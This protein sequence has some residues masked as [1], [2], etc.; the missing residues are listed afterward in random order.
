[1][2]RLQGPST[3]TI[4]PDQGLTVNQ[5]PASSPASS[6]AGPPSNNAA[7]AST[8]GVTGIDYSKWDNIGTTVSD[9]EEDEAQRLRDL[10]DREEL[11]ELEL[12]RKLAHQQK[13][14]QHQQSS[15]SSS[16]S[17]SSRVSN[18]SISTAEQK[19]PAQQLTR[20]GGRGSLLNQNH[21][22]STNFLWSQTATSLVLNF[23]VPAW[24]RAKQVKVVV[25]PDNNGAD[26]AV[27][28]SLQ[29]RHF[30]C[31]SVQ[32]PTPLE[33]KRALAHPIEEVEE[34]ED[35][36]W[37]LFDFCDKRRVQVSLQKKPFAKGVTLWWKKAFSDQN[38]GE[39]IDVTSISD[40]KQPASS[41]REGKTA[42]FQDNW[43][44]AQEMFKKKVAEREIMEI[45][46]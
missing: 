12:Q 6:S 19:D 7:A 29:V 14:Q 24:T 35:L 42:T 40:R 13:Q 17:K 9:D 38:A 22:T 5:K 11:D 8:T 10:D 37:E 1:M 15:S 39:E 4:G 30:V 3:V 26:G 34:V 46:C 44:K 20:N 32:G 36:D 31:L 16:S 43:L 27:V 25:V 2:T 33:F 41:G 45:D 28:P 23:E 21:S 18:G